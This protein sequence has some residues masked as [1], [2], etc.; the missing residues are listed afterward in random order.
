MLARLS[1][2]ALAHMRCPPNSRSVFLFFFSLSDR[3]L[4]YPPPCP[5][6]L[7]QCD[8]EPPATHARPRTH[9]HLHICLARPSVRPFL[10]FFFTTVTLAL[11]PSMPLMPPQ[12]D[13]DPSNTRTH[14]CLRIC[15]RTRTYLACPTVCHFFFLLFTSDGDTRTIPLYSMESSGMRWHHRDDRC[16]RRAVVSAAHLAL[17]GAPS[18]RS[19][20]FPLLM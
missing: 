5:C 12:P 15:A 11:S 10:F 8:D 7:P 17:T 20:P 16:A 18:C 9:T 4:C 6:P 19:S 14:T 1:V 2:Y 13:D 3:H